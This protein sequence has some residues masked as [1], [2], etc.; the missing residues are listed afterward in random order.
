MLASVA[1]LATLAIVQPASALT[2]KQCSE[3]YKTANDAGSVG[4]MS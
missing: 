3:K 1:A 2:M 4:T